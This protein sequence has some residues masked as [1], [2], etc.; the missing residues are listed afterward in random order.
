MAL[1][2][3]INN[4]VH[5]WDGP[6]GTNYHERYS[7][8]TFKQYLALVA[9]LALTSS[10]PLAAMKQPDK[11][12]INETKENKKRKRDDKNSPSQQSSEE[13]NDTKNKKGKI[14]IVQKEQKNS[15]TET[16][17]TETKQDNFK[18]PICLD[19]AINET[20]LAPIALRCDRKNKISHD[21]HKSCLIQY[22]VNEYKK[23]EKSF[24]CPICKKEYAIEKFLTKE[25]IEKITKISI[26]IQNA[27][28]GEPQAFQEILKDLDLF[29]SSDIIIIFKNAVKTGNISMLKLLL[30]NDNAI[31]KIGQHDISETLK[32]LFEAA[33][34][35]SSSN[36]TTIQIGQHDRTTLLK[37]LCLLLANDTITTLITMDKNIKKLLIAIV[38]K[39]LSA[40]KKSLLDMNQQELEEKNFSNLIFCCAL[41]IKAFDIIAEFLTPKNKD[42]LLNNI[43]NDIANNS[44]TEALSL[45]FIYA[46]QNGLLPIFKLFLEPC[47]K[48][49]IDSL[50]LHDQLQ[51]Q[52][53]LFQNFGLGMTI[54]ALTGPSEAL[55]RA[56]KNNQLTIV[57]AL[58]SSENSNVVNLISNT[59]LLEALTLAGCDE[60]ITIARFL[61]T[62]TIA[63]NRISQQDLEK[64]SQQ[65]TCQA[66]IE[67]IKKCIEAKNNKLSCLL[68]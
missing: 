66:F 56:I 53:Q 29:W 37:L 35:A 44:S 57:Q 23:S 62:N 59:D 20:D 26:L 25:E 19:T 34:E 38:K 30:N 55:K 64:L 7:M 54:E 63:K 13:D 12:E 33:K 8:N 21:F 61:L 46:A 18:C 2:Y 40:F 60:H 28:D 11:N 31:T 68:Q 65:T 5:P 67:E 6:G 50:A 48:E 51:S 43:K 14:V 58:F 32:I 47:N 52:A 42:L 15:I 41:Q 1:Q 17:N 36:Q 22:I 24:Q 10:L 3:P 39:D 27:L 49:F 4:E 16:T 45:F 9:T